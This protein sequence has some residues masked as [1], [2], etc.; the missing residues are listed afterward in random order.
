[1]FDSIAWRYDF[2]NHFLSFNIDRLWRRKAIKILS[3]SFKSQDPRCCY[4]YGRSGDCCHEA[5]PSKISGIDISVKMLEIGKEKIKK[6]GLSERSNLSKE[7]REDS[8]WCQYIWVAMA[9]FGVRNFSDPLKGLMEMHRV[10]QNK[11]MIMI[12]EFSKPSVFPFKPLYTSISKTFSSFRANFSRDKT[13][14]GTCLI[15]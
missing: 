6:K 5:E 1:M 8:F 11:G 15:R 10:I 13:V 3:K 7:I 2:L 4:W 14:I 9:A 12:L